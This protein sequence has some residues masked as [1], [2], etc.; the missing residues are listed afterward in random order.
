M[1][2]TR[3]FPE[4]IDLQADEINTR[5]MLVAPH[6]RTSIHNH[7][8]RECWSITSGEGLL[9]S[10]NRHV[11]VGAGDHVEFAP[12]ET[13]MI[14]NSADEELRF[15]THWFTDWEAI[16]SEPER[17]PGPDGRVMIGAAFPSPNG[18]L[19]LGHLSGPFLMA[20][21]LRRCCELTGTQS[22]TYCGTF[23]NTNHI[24][25]TA[26][27][28]GTTYESL[29]ARSEDLIR[30]DLELFETHYDDFL[31]HQPSSAAFEAAKSSF[32]EILTASPYLFE[33]EV[34]HPYS[35]SEQVFV[36]ESFVS[37][38]CPHCASITIGLECES[39]G[40]YQD[41]CKLIEPFHSVT[42]EPLAHRNV[43]KLYLRLDRDIL[44]QIAVQLYSHNTAASRICYDYLQKYLKHD[45]L[46]DIPV[47][48]LRSK[49]YPVHGDQVLS[50]AMER[51]LRS[52]QGLAQC[53]S[54]TRHLWFCGF[55]NLCA[56]GILVP[57]ILKVLGI[58][59]AQ[60]PI[61]V[62]NNFCLL[63]N[64]KF[65]T[66]A[67]HAIWANEFL[68]T[69]PAD[70]VRLYLSNIHRPTAESNFCVDTFFNYANRF[71]DTLI[72]CFEEGRELATHYVGDRIEAG[73]WLV[74]DVLLYR[75][76]NNAM[77]HCLESYSSQA[78]VVALRRIEH[79]LENLA[80]YIVESRHYR[81][82]RNVLR[83]RL[84]LVLYAYQS[85]AY[86]LY[87]VMPD[88]STCILDCL[89]VDRSLCHGNRQVVRIA[90]H[91]DVDRILDRLNQMKKKI[92]R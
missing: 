16:L 59:D 72:E 61:A 9:S 48:A 1:K 13:H 90:E 28:Q 2:I 56:S 77:R 50:V 24:D 18:P 92:R 68:R 32:I 44:N 26:I 23:G 34:A 3:A 66:G 5:D 10:G 27:A 84:A 22:F 17:S 71:T 11:V 45:M 65:S 74:Q 83:T 76:L 42:K 51:A 33:R 63:E 78:C 19:H 35:E 69:Y 80:D 49:G 82:D 46:G 21:I 53:T 38:Q 25:R 88:L 8:D 40:L 86:C 47:S 57:Y 85:L 60:L 67:N 7:H 81:D 58:P 52:Y 15:T 20:D 70:L 55:D 62:V 36:S 89:R 12:F 41:E 43:K 79:L 6:A 64:R 30:Q 54:V 75:E 91:F 87:P 4:S 29:V 31:P 73:P 14:A 39:C 37:G